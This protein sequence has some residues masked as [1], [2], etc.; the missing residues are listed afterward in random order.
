MPNTKM[1]IGKSAS[2][3]TAYV[4]EKSGSSNRR[5]ELRAAHHD[6]E[7]DAGHRGEREA[8]E[9]ARER[10]PCFGEQKGAREK[11]KHELLEDL[12]ERRKEERAPQTA[13]RR[14]FPKREGRGDENERQDGLHELS[15]AP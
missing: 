11:K 13:A 12:D 8:A 1:K 9:R 15:I 7:Q 3:G 14:R 2:F 4:P 10:G 6:A 5:D